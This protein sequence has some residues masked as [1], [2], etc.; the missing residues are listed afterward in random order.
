[1]YLTAKRIVT[2]TDACPSKRMA[3]MRRVGNH[4]FLKCLSGS[5]PSVLKTV[6]AASAVDQLISVALAQTGLRQLTV[7]HDSARRVS[8]RVGQAIGALRW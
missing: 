7:R 8:V 5:G 2:S 3:D 6:L 4:P 1:M